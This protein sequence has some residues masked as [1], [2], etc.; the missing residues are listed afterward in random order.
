LRGRLIFQVSIREHEIMSKDL[1][2][3]A[4]SGIYENDVIG[5][6]EPSVSGMNRRHFL[7]ASSAGIAAA[8][9]GIATTSA[10]TT[11]PAVLPTN[12]T[13]GK[14]VAIVTDTVLSMGPH[15][16]RKFAR[17]GYN[18]VIADP[19][20]GLPEELRGLGAD[21]VVVPGIEQ[22]GANNEGKPGSMQ[23]LVDTAMDKFGGFDSAFIRTAAHVGNNILEET[24]ENM[25][26]SYEQNCMAVLYALQ[27]VL[28][29]LMKAGRGQ[30]VI[31]TSALGEKPA[32]DLVAYS[33]MRA[34][35]NMMVR[36]AAMTAAP[37]GVCVNAVGTN[38]MN[39]PGFKEAS[40]ASDPRVMEAILKLI[41]LGRLGEPEEAAHFAMSLLDGY[42]MYA[43]GN[44]F[45]ITGGFN[46]AGL[47][48]RSS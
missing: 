13:S 34:A 27:A 43:T 18:L 47:P 16:A 29:P 32:P 8:G 40:H 26:K 10:Q 24:V 1:Q 41:P 20:E 37:K 3:P 11:G 46:N 44:C 12:S 33:T 5:S 19:A 42:N 28:P 39:Y 30:V 6:K 23:K 31:Q 4:P 25:Q 14:R 21:V 7:V 9:A 38:F 22:D 36:C 17:N 2:S 15:L 35:A 45:T 48:I